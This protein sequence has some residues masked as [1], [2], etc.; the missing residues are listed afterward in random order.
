MSHLSASG[1]DKF[2][3]CQFQY[4]LSTIYKPR[5]V[6]PWLKQGIV[7]HSLLE[8]IEPASRPTAMEVSMANRLREAEADMGYVIEE[9]EVYDS[10]IIA[11]MELVRRIDAKGTCKDEAVIV[12]YKTAGSIWKTLPGGIAPQAMGFQAAVYLVPPKGADWPKRIDFLVTDGAESRRFTY[13]WNDYD[14]DSL[15]RAMRQMKRAMTAK[16]FIKHRGW[17]CNSC[18]WAARCFEMD[19][20]EAQY[21]R[22]ESADAEDH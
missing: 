10:V 11:G 7:V 18:D 21:I 13:R 3:S 5:K 12:D 4:H 20:W 2:F 17:G 15:V 19:G 6:S 16:R 14:Y 9:R 1:L 22:R 8:G